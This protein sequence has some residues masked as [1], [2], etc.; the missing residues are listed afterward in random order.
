MKAVLTEM[1]LE[2]F[3]GVSEKTIAFG[4]NLTQIN[5]KNGL[6]KST[7][8]CAYLWVLSDVNEHLVSN[9]DVYPIG[10]EEASP[11]V[12]IKM[13]IDG[14]NVEF[15]RKLKRTVK[16][17]KDGG[18]DSVSFTSIYE[19]NTVEYGLRDYKAKLAEYGFDNDKLLTLIHPDVFVSEKKDVMRKVLF[20]MASGKSDLE[21]AQLTDGAADV[22]ELMKD[23][24]LEEI[25]SMQKSTIRKINEEYGKSGEILNAK[26]EGLVSAKV[27]ID[28]AELELQ[29]NGLKEEIAKFNAEK[30]QLACDENELKNLK[31]AR[32]GVQDKI[33]DLNKKL[34]E[35]VNE[36]R[37]D[38]MNSA[39]L[40]RGT[41]EQEQ[42]RFRMNETNISTLK[43]LVEQCKEI[44]E[45]NKALSLNLSE[46]SFDESTGVCPTCGR[47][48]DADKL[49]ALKANFEADKA[50]KIAN[51]KRIM[52]EQ[53]QIAKGYLDN[54]KELQAQNLELKK[55][56]DTNS[57]TAEEYEIKAKEIGMSFVNVETTDE[58]KAIIAEN[59]KNSERIEEIVRNL[60]KASAIDTAIDGKMSEISY[61]DHRIGLMA[62]ND[63]IDDK[64]KELRSKQGEYEQN[65][66]NAEK[67]LYELEL[68]S[69]TKNKLLTDEINSYFD[70]VKW[71]FW[72]FRKNGNYE[73]TCEC[74]IDNKLFGTSTNTGREVLAKIDIIHGLQRF[75]NQ[76]LPLFLDN[77]ESL[78]DESKARIN[79][80]TQLI[81]LN[82]TNDKELTIG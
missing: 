48:Y 40:L 32:A 49:E 6:G 63:E 44:Y 77:A 47:K 71:S 58:Y 5:G 35:K 56:I 64:I 73:E 45:E 12:S 31:I 2:N 10:V 66:A 67:I 14:K 60:E 17:S 13:V 26:I 27:D 20:G 22:V 4:E 28:V 9:P 24:S 57:K 15:A 53:N 21:V 78:S 19:V 65:L 39:N 52:G 59:E 54:I 8:M 16:K 62:R 51:A 7:L 79:I 42:K 3:K 41:V 50:K 33:N 34:N 18:A 38:L 36:E 55:S 29:K 70:I 80:D 75:Y 68:I 69:K 74:Y 76:H 72:K 25:A 46:T 11:K 37:K 30:A 82:V 23:Y 81:F 1:T 61:I 43:N